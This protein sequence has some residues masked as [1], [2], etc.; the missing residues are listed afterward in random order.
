MKLIRFRRLGNEY[1]EIA[2]NQEHL[3]SKLNGDMAEVIMPAKPWHV[4]LWRVCSQFAVCLINKFNRT[5]PTL[6]G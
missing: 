1:W 6:K 2:F 3:N 5:E 4:R